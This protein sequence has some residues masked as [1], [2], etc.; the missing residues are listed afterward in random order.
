MR[1]KVS[2]R[3]PVRETRRRTPKTYSTEEKARVVFDPT[4]FIASPGRGRVTDARSPS[5]RKDP[6]FSRRRSECLVEGP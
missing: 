5:T 1:E 4:G 6:Q 2:A 3:E